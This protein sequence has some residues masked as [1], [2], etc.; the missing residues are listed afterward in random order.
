MYTL[1]KLACAILAIAILSCGLLFLEGAHATYV[2]AQTITGNTTWTI[3]NSPYF[4]QGNVVVDKGVTLTILPGVTVNFGSY[5]LTVAGTLKAQGSIG[6]VIVFSSSGFS[7]QGINFTP[8]SISSIID[9]ALIYSVPIIINGGYTQISN[10]Y[11]ASTPTTPITV[12]S[13]SSSIQSNTINFQSCNGIQI[14]GGS[15]S[16]LNNLIIGQGQN[17]GIYTKGAAIITNNNITNCFSGIYAATQSTIQQNNI[18]YN[19]NDGIRSDNSS[20]LIQ[21]N[22][23]AN[24][25]CGVSGTGDIESNTITGNSVGI[26]GPNLTA[27]ITLNNIFANFNATGGYVQNIHMTFLDNLSFPN[28]WWGLTDVSAI[29]QTI[30]DFKNDT[31]HLG[32]V[33]FSPF[34]NQ[35]NPNAPSVPTVIPVPTPPLSPT[36]GSTSTPTITPSP[37]SSVTATPTPTSVSETHSIFD[38]RT[39]SYPNAPITTRKPRHKYRS[40]QHDGHN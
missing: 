33:N 39:K 28:N 12:N 14:N 6:M 18:M 25:L 20:S 38:S 10:S 30:W 5:Q 4:L 3:Q 36:P 29:N 8:N 37:T 35:A 26:W 40:I 7:N 19:I 2:Y 16:I 13:A 23:I 1:R 24:N 15:V 21:N 27:T 31:A 34:L 22:A 17:Y 32:I 9:D 11:F